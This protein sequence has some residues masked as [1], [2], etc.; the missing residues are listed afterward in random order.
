MI[1]TKPR[2]VDRLATLYDYADEAENAR[3]L[4]VENYSRSGD[5]ERAPAYLTPQLQKYQPVSDPVLALSG[6]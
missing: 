1:E 6:H 4:A 2:C 5:D 3:N